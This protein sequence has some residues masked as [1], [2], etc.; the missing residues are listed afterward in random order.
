MSSSNGV[1]PRAGPAP[2][3]PLHDFRLDGWLVEPSRNRLV[4]GTT[5]IRVRPQLIDVLTC[6]ATRPG[7]VVSKSRLLSEVWCDR[8]V[9]ETGIARCMAEL[10]QL[11][12][13]DAREPRII[14]TI[15]KRG[16]RLIARVEPLHAP[17]AIEAPPPEAA[18]RQAPPAGP[19]PWH[20]SVWSVTRGILAAG[21][22]LSEVVRHLAR[23]VAG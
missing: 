18:P 6:L 21:A 3:P 9:S 17:A 1:A 13:D 16:Y 4:K 7:Q 2:V 12:A 15:P 11:L 14:E 20:T 22:M 8:Y 5:A 19:T 23:R 10:R